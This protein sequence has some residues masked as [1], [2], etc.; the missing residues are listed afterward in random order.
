ML[1]FSEA[2]IASTPCYAAGPPA[3]AMGMGHDG[4][5]DRGTALMLAIFCLLTRCSVLPFLLLNP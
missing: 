1:W 5:Q 3:D 2:V 4:Q